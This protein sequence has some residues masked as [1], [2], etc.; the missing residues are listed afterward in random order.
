MMS[1][2]YK[3]RTTRYMNQSTFDS[4]KHQPKPP[5]LQGKATATR[6]QQVIPDKR[7][8]RKSVKH[9]EDKA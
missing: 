3:K 2:N 7:A 9:V 1:F 4:G 8:R 5:K 6:E